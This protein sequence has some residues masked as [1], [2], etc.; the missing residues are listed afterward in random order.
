MYVM[1]A[2]E[3]ERLNGVYVNILKNSGVEYIGM[4]GFFL[5]P[6]WYKV[7]LYKEMV[8]LSML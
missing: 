4:F 6:L 2:K 5:L 1:Q 7:Y 3:I 8:M